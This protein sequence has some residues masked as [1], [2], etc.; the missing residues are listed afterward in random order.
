MESFSFENHW[1][2]KYKDIYEEKKPSAISWFFGTA[3][4]ELCD[5]VRKGII[6]RGSKFVDLGCG[7]GMEAL[8]MAVHGMEVIGVD[9]SQSALNIGQQLENIYGTKVKW[10]NAD[11]LKT[12]I[13]DEYADVVS[14]N[15]IFHN[16]K[17]VPPKSFS[18]LICIIFDSSS[19]F[20]SEHLI[21]FL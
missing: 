8:F 20:L 19:L 5:L 18:A 11:V 21:S 1:N 4:P 13:E 2:E 3:G 16:I 14:D 9:N 6:K 15:F 10:I 12:T 17:F 7:I